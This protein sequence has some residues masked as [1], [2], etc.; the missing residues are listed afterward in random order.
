MLSMMHY[1]SS[2]LECLHHSEEQHYTQNELLCPVSGIKA[3]DGAE[4]Q[5][6]FDDLFVFPEEIII[7]YPLYLSAQPFTPLLGRAPPSMI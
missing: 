1:H 2:G 4:S 3:V 6:L 5:P 7:T